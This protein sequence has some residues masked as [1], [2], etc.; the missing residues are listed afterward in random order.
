M[1]NF[2]FRS[3]AARTKELTVE[4]EKRAVAF[5]VRRR[6]SLRVGLKHI[7]FLSTK[8]GTHPRHLNNFAAFAIVFLP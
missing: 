3:A 4:I 1:V 6:N 5:A 7:A 2:R 8:L